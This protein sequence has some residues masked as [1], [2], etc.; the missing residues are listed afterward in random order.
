MNCSISRH[1]TIQVFAPKFRDKSLHPC[2]SQF[3]TSLC[4]AHLPR[5]SSVESNEVMTKSKNTSASAEAAASEATN[6]AED[7]R[8]MTEK[9]DIL[10]VEE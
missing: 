1:L 8:A 2:S 10:K 5:A 9:D 3:P 6:D 4:H 7:A